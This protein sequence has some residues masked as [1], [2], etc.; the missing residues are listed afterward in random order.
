MFNRRN[1]NEIPEFL[2]NDDEDFV[3]GEEINWDDYYESPKKKIK[4]KKQ[5]LAINQPKK[6][7]FSSNNSL[8]NNEN[9][10]DKH[11]IDKKKAIKKN[12]F[13]MI[14]TIVVFIYI[15]FVGCG[16]LLTTF[17]SQK[18]PQ[19]ISVELRELRNNY[20]L[21]KKHYDG[22]WQLMVLM[23]KYDKELVETNY[24]DAFTYSV[25]YQA[26]ISYCDEGLKQ[27][28][29]AEYNVDYRQ[30]QFE[31][32]QIYEEIK[33]Y[34]QSMTMAL[35]TNSQSQFNE[36]LN[37]RVKI[38]NHFGIYDRNMKQFRQSVQLEDQ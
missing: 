18:K 28:K 9:I 20:Y 8:F 1:D 15:V 2:I 25:K 37:M 17:D 14:A 19:I 10:Y 26:L 27:V 6:D 11:E 12:K 36:A 13:K 16:Y 21:A 7:N 34:L 30:L 38:I 29:G 22:I 35:S 23:D 5:K 32:A 33:T 4:G 31:N 24:S 3:S